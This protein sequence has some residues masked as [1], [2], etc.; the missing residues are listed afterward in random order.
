MADRVVLFE[1]T[2][3]ASKG[4]LQGVGNADSLLVGGIKRGTGS[5]AIDGSGNITLIGPSLTL[6]ATTVIVN[7]PI[8]MASHLIHNVTNPVAA[9]DAATKGYIDSLDTNNIKKDGSVAFTAD[10]SMGGHKLTSVAAPVAGGDA[11]NKTYV[12]TQEALDLRLDGSRLMTGALNMNT[13]LISNVVNPVSAQ[14][15][16]TK[17]YVDTLE[18]LDVRLDGSRVMT[19]ALDMGTHLIHNVVNPVAAQDAAT[20]NYVDGLVAGSSGP[21]TFV[22]QATGSLSTT[23]GSPVD[24]PSSTF[25]FTLTGT[26]SVCFDISIFR[27]LLSMGQPDSSMQ[28]RLLLLDTDTST[29]Y[30]VQGYYLFGNASGNPAWVGV[31]D[32]GGNGKA[33]I[34]LAAG[35]H[36]FKLQVIVDS[37]TGATSVNFTYPLNIVVTDVGP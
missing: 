9:Q 2:T 25:S 23:S 21:L 1:N 6:N 11:T 15:A 5:L 22:H 37:G 30:D 31:T 13:H 36:H 27:A 14:D 16:A 26:R 17:N 19:G 24:L 18:A 10:E 12:D 3:G 35:T 32:F 7:A 8:D 20:K 34:S 4:A 28:A 29:T 33:I